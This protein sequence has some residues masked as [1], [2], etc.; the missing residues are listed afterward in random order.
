[1]QKQGARVKRALQGSSSERAAADLKPNGSQPIDARLLLSIL[2]EIRRGNF[3]V[4]M[5]VGA[6][7]PTARVA[8]EINAVIELSDRN[9]KNLAGV[10]RVIGAVAEG[11][12][13]APVGPELGGEPLAGECVAPA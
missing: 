10:A 1:A 11:D 6:D 9:A 8:S 5:P 13:A 4:R 2:R 3:S 12:L 7:G